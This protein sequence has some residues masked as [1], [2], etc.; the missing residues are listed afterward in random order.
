[1][2]KRTIVGVLTVMAFVLP[3][4]IDGPYWAQLLLFVVLGTAALFVEQSRPRP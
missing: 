3:V 1:M 2:S 4:A